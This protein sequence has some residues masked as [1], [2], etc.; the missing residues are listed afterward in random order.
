VCAELAL[1][2]LR[3]NEPDRADAALEEM[4]VH[5]GRV[6]DP[7]LA[8]EL[9]SQ[10]LQIAGLGLPPVDPV[11]HLARIDSVVA[12]AERLGDAKAEV[13]ARKQR[14]D[15]LLQAGERAALEAE[16]ERFRRASV[17]SGG[18]L[19]LR[20]AAYRVMLSTLSGHWDAAGRGITEYER[21]ADPDERPETPFTPVTQRVLLAR[22]DAEFAAAETDV[23]QVLADFPEWP[24]WRCALVY[25]LMRGEKRQETRVEFEAVVGDGL[26]P[27][28]PQL[29]GSRCLDRDLSRAKSQALSIDTFMDRLLLGPWSWVRWTKRR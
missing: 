24:T 21:L 17:R 22:D 16:C 6:E 7:A 23:R 18:R 15:Q 10:H 14:M 26:D 4:L 11:R 29:L 9:R 19:R 2:S 27:A 5:T 28:P 1:L 3:A 20:A 8:L 13:E 12:E 25:V